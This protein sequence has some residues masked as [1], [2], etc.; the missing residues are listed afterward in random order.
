MGRLEKQQQRRVIRTLVAEEGLAGVKFLVANLSIKL[1]QHSSGFK[2]SSFPR[3]SS[4]GG[5]IGPGESR[6]SRGR[7]SGYRSRRRH[8][9]GMSSGS[10]RNRCRSRGR[11]CHAL[12]RSPGFVQEHLGIPKIHLALE[13]ATEGAKIEFF[14]HGFP[15]A[16][17]LQNQRWFPRVP[18]WNPCEVQVLEN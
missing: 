10:R 18:P 15:P 12:F 1:I 6:R 5:Y 4:G 7:R 14:S 2:G 11:R 3:N 16:C 17:D 9:G 13:V 8:G